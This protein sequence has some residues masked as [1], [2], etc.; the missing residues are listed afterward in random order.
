ML[1]AVPQCDFVRKREELVLEK[2]KQM[3]M[4]AAPPAVDSTAN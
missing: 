2:Q 4:I 3:R 1:N